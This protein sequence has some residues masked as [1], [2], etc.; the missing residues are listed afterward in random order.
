MR[1]TKLEYDEMRFRF[2]SG[3]LCNWLW[4]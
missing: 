2:R 3:I 1:T 4:L